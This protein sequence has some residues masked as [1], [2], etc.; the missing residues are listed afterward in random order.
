ML[1]LVISKS[2]KRKVLD[3]LLKMSGSCLFPGICNQIALAQT[4]HS[5]KPS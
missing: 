2:L 1:E 3:K 4:V 5:K